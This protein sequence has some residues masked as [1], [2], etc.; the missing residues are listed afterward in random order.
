MKCR[1]KKTSTL[2]EECSFCS[3]IEWQI[4]FG[5]H[6][7]DILGLFTNP[8]QKVCVQVYPYGQRA[9]S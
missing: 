9:I 8:L 6:H 3:V 7:R 4:K 1:A 2:D 5:L